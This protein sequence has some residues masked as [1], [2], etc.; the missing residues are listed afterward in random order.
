[1]NNKKSVLSVILITLIAHSLCCIMPII[2]F[3][4]GLTSIG[5]HVEV[6]HQY[7][8]LLIILNV[9]SIVFGYYMYYLH[10]QS[11]CSHKHCHSSKKP[12]WFITIMSILLIIIPHIYEFAKGN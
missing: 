10:R 7:E 6:I 11:K 2:C 4:I 8:G 12:F 5:Q 3:M 9:L 1:M